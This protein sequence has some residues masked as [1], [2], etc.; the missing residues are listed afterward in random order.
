[1]RVGFVGWR[2]MVSSVLMDRM[3]AERDFD[4][5]EPVF[6]STSSPGTTAPDVGQGAS[7]LVDARDLSALAAQE[8]ILTC[9]GG[10][11][12]QDV[13]P[14]LRA[15]GW[16]G[17]WIDAASALRM[18]S[19]AMLVLDPVNGGAIEEALAS[20][21]KAFVGANCTCLLYTSPSPRDS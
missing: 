1:M 18:S 15:Q 20:G 2:G 19:E 7:L 9:Q 8:V 4:G 10:E 13:Y 6:F 3:R 14:R 5:L 11:Y 12:T 21:V 16:D 17:I